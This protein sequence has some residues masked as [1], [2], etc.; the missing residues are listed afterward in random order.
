MKEIK[1]QEKANLISHALYGKVRLEHYKERGFVVSFKGSK[2]IFWLDWSRLK[3]IMDK[4]EELVKI[5]KNLNKK[6]GKKD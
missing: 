4:F 5:K 1:K 3:G 2:E 6:N